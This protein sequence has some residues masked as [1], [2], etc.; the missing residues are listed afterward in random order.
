M[1][2]HEVDFIINHA[3]KIRSQYNANKIKKETSNIT[4]KTKILLKSTLHQDKWSLTDSYRLAQGQLVNGPQSTPVHSSSSRLM[5]L[6]KLL[7]VKI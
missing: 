7:F 5:D 2:E 4:F 6:T 3:Q 1:H